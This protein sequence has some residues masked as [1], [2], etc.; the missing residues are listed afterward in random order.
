LLGLRYISSILLLDYAFPR[1]RVHSPIIP[2][3]PV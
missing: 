2:I 3:V 1:T